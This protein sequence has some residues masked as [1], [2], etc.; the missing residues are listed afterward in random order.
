[1]IIANLR[2]ARKSHHCLNDG[3]WAADH[4]IWPGMTYVEVRATP[5]DGDVGTGHWQR[6]ALCESDGR[7]VHPELFEGVA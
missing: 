6:G 4:R 3:T 2:R 7:N 5:N 1:M